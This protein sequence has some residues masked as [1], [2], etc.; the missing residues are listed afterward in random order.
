MDLRS[1]ACRSLLALMLLLAVP[2][3]A[4]AG[5]GATAAPD[6]L[7]LPVTKEA[8]VKSPRI[9]ASA[10]ILMDGQT[11]QI[12]FERN[13][14]ARREPAST[15]KILTAIIILEEA[16]LADKVKVSKK[17]ART[18][19]STMHLVAGQVHS[20]HD[21]VH[22]LLL[23]SGNDAAVALAEYL[24]GSE[25]A[26]AAK[27]NERARA[28]GAQASHFK[29]P[30]GLPNPAH[31]TTAYDLARITQY[32][33]RNPKFAQIVGS[34]SAGLTYEELDRDVVL[35]NTNRLLHMLP[36]ADGVKTGTTGNAGKCLVFS[37]TRQGQQLIGVIL[38]D[39]NRF[40]D[41]ATLLRW[42]FTTFRLHQY[43]K[44][45]DLIAQ[46]PLI[47]GKKESLPLKLEKGLALVLPA[48]AQVPQLD[49]KLP[50]T[51]KAPVTA[52]AVVGEALVRRPDG[53][54]LKSRL[55]AAET[56]K[57]RTL[58]EELMR[59]VNQQRG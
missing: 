9:V 44:A 22:G 5:P 58:W 2:V 25:E 55:L 56:I 53:V 50:P 26:F 11:G 12:L 17:A 39:G 36:E 54:E 19:G 23:R 47:R 38:N 34:R 1:Y 4:L 40:G 13:A 35:H 41:A 30:H 45:G 3:P 21:L 52:G 6:D 18:E 29:N 33:M 59:L 20:V 14:H 48:G 49:L 57:R 32:A 7:V 46:A 43:G 28:M 31:Y 42:G 16:N 37:G 10:A 27:M 24:S 51:L 8:P 15:T